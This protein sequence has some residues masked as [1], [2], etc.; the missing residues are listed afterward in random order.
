[1]RL[2][3][4]CEMA[5]LALA[6]G[7]KRISSC[8]LAKSRRGGIGRRAGLK[9]QYWQQCVGSIPSVGRVRQRPVLHV[10]NTFLGMR[11][12]RV[13]LPRDRRCTSG[14]HSRACDV[15]DARDRRLNFRTPTKP[16]IPSSR[17]F[18]RYSRSMDV[19]RRTRRSASHATREAT[20]RVHGHFTSHTRGILAFRT[21]NF[22]FSLLVE[23]ARL[24]I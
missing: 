3:K 5:S 12:G 14:T 9:I 18:V 22:Y 20:S 1:M 2:L 6:F 7:C 8:L 11:R 10:W 16:F 21:P 24:T 19:L 13:A 15:V 4:S 23:F 17:V